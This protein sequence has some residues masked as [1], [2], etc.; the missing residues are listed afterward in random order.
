MK[1]L[2]VMWILLAGARATSAEWYETFIDVRTEEELYDLYDQGEIGE[3]SLQALVALLQRGVDLNSADR[4]ELYTLPN[5]TLAE[6]D[7]ILA[8]RAERGARLEPVGVVESGL[9]EP[10]KAAALDAFLRKQRM[11]ETS[12]WFR[13]QAR[14]LLP[15]ETEP[16]MA[17]QGRL[18]L[19]SL[20]AGVASIF[21][22]RELGAVRFDP[23]RAALSAQP[24]T[25]HLEV[26]KAYLHWRGKQVQALLGSFRVGFGQRLTFDN[27]AQA[28]P[29][30]FF[31]DDQ[32]ARPSETN[33]F[34]GRPA[35]RGL[36]I[37][38]R[39]LPATG[40]GLDA[41]MFASL[42]PRALYQYEVCARSEEAGCASPPVILTQ[43]D[44][45]AAAPEISHAVLPNMVRELVAGGNFTF[46]VGTRNHLAVTGYGA[47][48][49]F[50]PRGVALEFRE[51]SAF[52]AGGRFGAAGID[53]AL[54]LG[55]TSLFAE[56]TRSVDR[57]VGGGFAALLRSVTPWTH[58]QLDASLRYY[59]RDFINPY[60]RPIAA[61]DEYE[62]N[63]ARDEAGVRIAYSGR[64]L[65]PLSVR[66]ISDLWISPESGVRKQAGF[67][68]ADYRIWPGLVL[69]TSVS[70]GPAAFTLRLRIQPHVRFHTA[71][72]LERGSATVTVWLQA[73]RRVWLRAREV[74]DRS[75]SSLRSSLDLMW[76]FRAR[77]LLR[78]RTD[79]AFRGSDPD[80]LWLQYESNF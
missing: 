66:A 39:K 64:P 31:A 4:A 63:R 6:V 32:I 40:A 57:E 60:A 12:G 61:A 49:Q 23:G 56:V 24:V 65:P 10:R 13:S 16:A 52:P 70:H 44:P 75:D 2:W 22:T 48:A 36:A 53:G 42:Q 47:D 55:R 9:L 41:T 71:V 79:L 29:D 76:R 11:P 30:G 21:V 46:R 50:L 68:R 37:A 35:L 15:A 26:P 34:A 51:S 14:T 73:L 8:Y 80:S 78:V 74:M 59:D 54:A 58:H 62:G 3:D 33:D 67:L 69:G 43:E 28:F 17:V 1:T 7:A 45:F 38:A 5:L 20:R 19:G 77:D 72:Q 27:T 18:E 25:N